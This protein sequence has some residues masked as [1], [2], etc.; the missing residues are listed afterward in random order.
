MLIWGFGQ[1]RVPPLQDWCRTAE[2]GDFPE[3]STGL[4]ATRPN[5]DL[6]TGSTTFGH[7]KNPPKPFV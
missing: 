5:R 1:L 3:P 4:K 6:Q 7:A 2:N